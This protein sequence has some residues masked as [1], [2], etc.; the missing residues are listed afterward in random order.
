VSNRLI[1]YNA[2]FDGNIA[3]CKHAKSSQAFVPGQFPVAAIDG[4]ISTKWQPTLSNNTASITVDVGNEGVGLHIS[5][6]AVD[7]AQNPPSSWQVDFS[8]SYDFS[9]AKKVY[10]STNVSISSPYNTTK[11][12][13]IT[14]YASNTTYVTLSSPVPAT[15]FI[16]LSIFGNQ[17]DMSQLGAT[18]AEFAVLRQGGGRLVPNSV[19]TAL[20]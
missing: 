3:Q 15:R 8:A 7:W 12:S 11:A 14:S 16:R 5:G 4:A 6:F 18:V 17:G 1:G 10:N 9:S 19:V 13:D 2:T 20:V